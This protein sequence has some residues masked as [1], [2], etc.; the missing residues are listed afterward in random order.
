[1][2][3]TRSNAGDLPFQVKETGEISS[4][5]KD[6]KQTPANKLRFNIAREQCCLEKKREG[7]IHRGSLYGHAIFL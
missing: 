7:I 3:Y 5:E 6:T 2:L 4:K 1:L